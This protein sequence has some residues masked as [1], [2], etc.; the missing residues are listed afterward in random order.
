M[1]NDVV[2]RMPI[3]GRPVPLTDIE[4]RMLLEL[5]V[6]AGRVPAFAELPQRAWGPEH[7]NHTG[8]ARSVLKNL[9]RK[10]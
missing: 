7:S 4:Y 8:A 10:L 6:N 9:R 1:V 2:R 5:S 3:A